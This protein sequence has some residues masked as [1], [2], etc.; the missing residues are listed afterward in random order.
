MPTRI[1][2]VC[3]HVICEAKAAPIATVIC[4]CDDCQQAAHAIEALPAAP[5]ILD[6]FGGT[7][8]TLF[9]QDR[10]ICVQG[11]DALVPRKLREASVTNRFVASCCNTFIYLGFDKGPHWVSVWTNRLP[12]PQPPAEMRVMTK[13]S[14]NVAAIPGD[15][16]NARS[17]AFGFLVK[18]LASRI[19][20]LFGK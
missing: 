10:F 1:A 6:P 4:C 12:A 18:V 16:P 19:P 5:A 8:L 20:M 2:C 3:G 17:F 9:R 13:Y 14:P 11:E 15:I 7:K